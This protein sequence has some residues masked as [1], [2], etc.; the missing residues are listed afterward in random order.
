MPI[1][2]VLVF[3][4]CCD[5]LYWT[6]IGPLPYLDRIPMPSNNGILSV[7]VILPVHHNNY[8]IITELC[9]VYD[10]SIHFSLLDNL[11]ALHE[12]WN[13]NALIRLNSATLA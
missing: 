9:C 11:R 4:N 12:I 1:S 3:W 10:Y 13:E 2:E 8:G 6:V 5:I 7:F